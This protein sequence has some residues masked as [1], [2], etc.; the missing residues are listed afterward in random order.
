MSLCI[1]WKLYPKWRR[2]C[3]SDQ[4]LIFYKSTIHLF[5]QQQFPISCTR[6]CNSGQIVTIHT[7]SNLG[8][9]YYRRNLFMQISFLVCYPSFSPDVANA[10]EENGKRCSSRRG[11]AVSNINFSW[12]RF[13]KSRRGWR[14]S[15]PSARPSK[16][17]EVKTVWKWKSKSTLPV[18]TSREGQPRA[19]YL[20]RPPSLSRARARPNGLSIPRLSSLRFLSHTPAFFFWL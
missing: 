10:P 19:S 4:T 13:F 14:L 17:G 5:I 8:C 20:L 6:N 11:P 9:L 12:G 18:E 7:N 15:R 3:F 1:V 2:T 16:Q